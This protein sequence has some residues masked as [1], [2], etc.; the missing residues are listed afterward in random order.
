MDAIESRY[1][2]IAADFILTARRSRSS[3]TRNAY[4]GL[5]GYYGMLA[6][7]H[8]KQ[9]NRPSVAGHDR[10]QQRSPTA[11]AGSP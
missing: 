4:L 1:R 2:R 11:A 3:V 9:K 5:A 6:Q 8:A 10:P 7:F